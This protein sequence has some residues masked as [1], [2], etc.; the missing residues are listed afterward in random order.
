MPSPVHASHDHAHETTTRLRTAFVLNLTFTLVEVV[1]GL[2]TNS[3]AILSDSLHDLGDSLSIGFSWWMENRA[4]RPSQGRYS[5]GF[6]RLSLVAALVNAI[7]LI[8]GSLIVLGQAF[9]RLF[10]PQAS[11]A[12]G[13]L[14]LAVLGI[15]VNGAAVL[16][17]RGGRGMNAQMIAWHLLE[18]VL[19]WVAVLIVSLS[20]L[21]TEIQILDPLLSMLITGY[22]LYNVIRNLRKTVAIFLQAA[23]ADLDVHAI[24]HE[25]ET[26]AH[27]LSTHHTHAWSLDGEH[28][29][30]TTHLVVPAGASKTEIVQVKAD[31]LRLFRQIDLE[32]TTIEVEYEDED[33]RMR[34]E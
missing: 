14:I 15:V 22:V 12:R 30:L 5:Y 18:D 31:A 1:G 34:D 20:L 2:F 27:V 25:L 7:I 9:P 24:E 32:H 4:H 8:L 13:M 33:C 19:G 3:L 21:V 11:N 16:R 17:M 26:I 23:P 6:R 28:H 29:V 10:D